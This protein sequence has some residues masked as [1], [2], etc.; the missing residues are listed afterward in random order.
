MKKICISIIIMLL[1]LA[2][3]IIPVY[4]ASHT[5]T[6]TVNPAVKTAKLGDTVTIDIGIAD[7]DQSTDGISAIGGF[8]KFDSDLIESVDINTMPN[9][10]V[11]I[12][13][14][15]QDEQYKG[16]FTIMNLGS[17]KDTQVIARLHAKIRSDATV[18]SGSITLKDVYSSYGNAETEK[19]TK[20]V[21]VNIA[22]E[23][24]GQED[25]PIIIPDNPDSGTPSTPDTPSTPASPTT[26]SKS[27]S[28]S[29]G[30]TT[31]STTSKATALPKAGII[32]SGIGIAVLAAIIVAIIEL[33]KYKKIG[34]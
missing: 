19:T 9:W 5:F 23:G 15:T 29:T 8:L 11:T 32:A 33:I 20:I 14:E 21:T 12:N 31:T 13:N 4:G 10:S 1:I 27:T 24:G 17:V 6:L 34:K 2:S 16:K 22:E 30:T 3:A 26:P 25:D 18:K 7:I 28:K